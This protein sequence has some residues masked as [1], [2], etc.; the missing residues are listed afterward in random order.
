MPDSVY[1]VIFV[2]DDD[3]R[4]AAALRDDLSRRFGRD[5]RLIAETSAASGLDILRELEQSGVPVA[6]LIADHNMPE[7]SGIDFLAGAHRLHPLA[8][9]CCWSSV[10]TPRAARWSRR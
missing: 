6:L 4:V 1:P 9:A 10:T 2:I 5:F 7:M 3:A 8:S